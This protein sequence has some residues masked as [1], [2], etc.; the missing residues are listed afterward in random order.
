MADITVTAANTAYVSGSVQR[1]YNA[2]ETITAGMSVYLKSSNSLWMKAKCAGTAEEAGNAV[3]TGIALHASLVNQPLAVQIDGVITIG[4]TVVVGSTYMISATYGG[5][6]PV[7]DLASTNKVS[8][9]GVGLTATTIG[10]STITKGYAGVA[11]P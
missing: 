3:Q 11:I 1:A 7:A 8:Y 9:L 4:G 10:L 5:V 6:C 2:G